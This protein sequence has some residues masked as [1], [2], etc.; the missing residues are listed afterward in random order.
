M[1]QHTSTHS[2]HHD[3]KRGP[4]KKPTTTA[5]TKRAAIT[6]SQRQGNNNPLIIAP[7]RSRH[8]SSPSP[9][10]L[11]PLT[12][13]MNPPTSP[14][15]HIALPVSP[16]A[17]LKSPRSMDYFMHPTF[18]PSPK[19]LGLNLP[20][21]PLSSVDMPWS[22]PPLSPPTRKLSNVELDLPIHD[23]SVSHGVGAYG[24]HVSGDEFE[25]LQAISQLSSS[26]IHPCVPT[27]LS[28]CST[29]VN[30]FRQHLELAQESHSRLSPR[31]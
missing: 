23:L 26:T 14:L 22:P 15:P 8:G 2:K 9:L 30:S 25:A 16:A 18:L 7:N 4:N 1:I 11:A 24:V 31:S 28:T 12:S 13:P 3:R 27:S 29:Q 5:S 10:L 6:T 17:E 20:A 21:S 19:D